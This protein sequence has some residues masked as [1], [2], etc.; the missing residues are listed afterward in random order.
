MSYELEKQI[1]MHGD[2]QNKYKTIKKFLLIEGEKPGNELLWKVLKYLA[3]VLIFMLIFTAILRYTIFIRSR[4]IPNITSIS[5][6]PD[7]IEAYFTGYLYLDRNKK[8]FV[9]V[10]AVIK[11]TEKKELLICSNIDASTY[12][13]GF[14]T[15]N[16][17]GVW[18]CSLKPEKIDKTVLGRLFFG[19][20]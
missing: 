11:K 2:L 7:K 19:Y 5:H 8:Y 12:F 13:A 6:Y 14:R 18:S 3:F 17:E 4:K 9:R 20:I 15:V 16:R 10:P 1:K